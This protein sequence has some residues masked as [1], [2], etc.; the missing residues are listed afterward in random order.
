MDCFHANRFKRGEIESIFSEALGRFEINVSEHGL[1]TVKRDQLESDARTT[2]AHFLGVKTAVRQRQL[3]NDTLDQRRLPAAG[4]TSEQKFSD[5]LTTFVS[6][7]AR[8]TKRCDR[9]SLPIS[10]RGR[11][12]DIYPLCHAVAAAMIR[13]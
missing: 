13:A 12:A 1:F 10:V 4:T 6:G 5:H 3:V 9:Q 7:N 11:N 2:L 8:K